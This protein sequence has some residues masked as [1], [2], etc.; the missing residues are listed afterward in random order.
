MSGFPALARGSPTLEGSNWKLGNTAMIVADWKICGYDM[1]RISDISL[2]WGRW[3][4]KV[5]SI[6]LRDST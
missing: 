4:P 6:P 3:N 1:L 5:M 2:H